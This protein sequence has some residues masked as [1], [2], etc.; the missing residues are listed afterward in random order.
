MAKCNKCNTKL[1]NSAKVFNGICQSCIEKE[2]EKEESDLLLELAAEQVEVGSKNFWLGMKKLLDLKFIHFQQSFARSM[3]LKLMS[4]VKSMI[5][6]ETLQLKQDI[7]TLKNENIEIEEKFDELKKLVID[8][9]ASIEMTDVHIKKQVDEMKE[10]QKAQKK[11]F[12]DTKK[13]NQDKLDE[14]EDRSR[15]NNLRIG[16]IIEDKNED[17]NAC[18]KKVKEFFRN[19]LKIEEEIVV[20]R[21]HRSKGKE[22][23]GPRVIVL[24]LLNYEN[25]ETILEACKLLKGTP[26][27]VS[28]D[29]C[30]NTVAIHKKLWKDIKDLRKEGKRAFLA[31][32]RIEIKGDFKN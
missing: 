21:A 20:Q 26:Y 11:E 8:L 14:Q 2:K 24:K 6:D 19:T 13:L 27:F 10:K 16:G 30:A 4:E 9:R 25:K 1:D 5:K 32:R 12:E 28:E 29:F 17:W 15:R 23:S 31:Y 7:E 18:K 22:G 3:E